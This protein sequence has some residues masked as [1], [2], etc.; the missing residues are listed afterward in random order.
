MNHH[1]K[2]IR[3]LKAAS[4]AIIFNN[5]AVKEISRR[6]SVMIHKTL[7]KESNLSANLLKDGL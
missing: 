4:R 5:F 3:Y 7:K 2:F 6:Y 1:F